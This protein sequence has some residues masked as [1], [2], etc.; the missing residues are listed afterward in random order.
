[1]VEISDAK[2]L[3]PAG[4]SA[5][6][7]I[8]QALDGFRALL[9][10]GWSPATAIERS[11]GQCGV[12]SVW[13]ARI[14]DQGS[15][16]GSTFCHGSVVVGGHEVEDLVDHCW[17]EISEAGDDFILD[18]TCNQAPRFERETV[19]ASKATLALEDVHYISDERVNISDLLNNPAWPR[20]ERLLLEIVLRIVT[21]VGGWFSLA[22]IFR[23]SADKSQNFGT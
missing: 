10:Q 21:A 12:S 6:T 14:L 11:R 4:L 7:H 22:T 5:Q 1:V 8:E 19:F 13:L 18:L 2:L 9:S 20:Y 16:I 3:S 17:L 15:S 23:E